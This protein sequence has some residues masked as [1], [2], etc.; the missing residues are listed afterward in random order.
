MALARRIAHHRPVSVSPVTPGQGLSS[1]L[2]P[3]A[4]ASALLMELIDSTAL[5]T[6]LPT[7]AQA[8]HAEPVELKLALTSYLL[9]LAVGAPAS[10]WVAERFGAKRVFLAAMGVFLLGSMLCGL[11]RSLEA[12]V[13]ARIVQ[14]LGG[15]MMTPVGRS[16]V[17]A[18]AP[19]ERFVA[20]MAWFSMPALV[21]PL[22]G[23]PLAGL[24]LS[25]ADWPWIFFINLPIGVL[26]MAAVAR[27]APEVIRP[28]PGRF[29]LKGF[30]LAAAA[31]TAVVILADTM[32]L[33]LVPLRIQ[34]AALALSL[35]FGAGF[36][37]HALGASRP[38]MNLRLLAYPTYRAS[39]IGGSLVRLGLGA[40]P[41]L[42]PLLLQIGLGWS[43]VR[44]G[45]V[46]IASGC[47]A[48]LCKP[49][50][51]YVIRR[52]GF[53]RVLIGASLL[54]A[55][56]IAAPG[57]FSI[58]TPTV[59]MLGVLGFGGFMRSLHFTSANTLAY[60]DIPPANIGQASTLTAVVQQVGM[61]LGVSLG[62]LSLH[63]AQRGV[64]TE[65]MTADRFLLPF[66]LTGLVS[67]LAAVV[68]WRLKPDAGFAISGAT[69]ATAP[70]A[71]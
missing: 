68:Y 53:R 56:L 31:V 60:A 33:S 17:V 24:I 46:T 54:A 7:L 13:A 42:L 51:S 39:L 52:F 5:S 8:F 9:A 59:V 10:G 45:L 14:G 67:A 30:L 65:D 63:L 70:P 20:A 18:A 16:I 38:V 2:A 64:A 47:G 23:P 34:L 66:L 71:S 22:L 1:R 12:L 44:A 37:L 40:T 43:P 11:S 58:Q 62:A 6:A 35:I 3:L 41:F 55:V 49:T 25:V 29:D 57:L 4:I 28:H 15:A 32:G 48:L 61:S 26:G 19:R 21:G 69:T 36:V 50:A 27:Y